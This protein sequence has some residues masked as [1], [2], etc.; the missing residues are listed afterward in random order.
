MVFTVANCMYHLMHNCAFANAASLLQRQLLTTSNSSHVRVTS[1]A[2]EDFKI[3]C[4]VCTL[5]ETNTGIIF[6]NIH[7]VFDGVYV[8]L[9]CRNKNKFSK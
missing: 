1:I 6:N 3:V 5:D 7:S 8:R 2:R 4:L 9:R